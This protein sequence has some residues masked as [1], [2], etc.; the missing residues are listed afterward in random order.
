MA[1]LMK[2][3]TIGA[4]SVYNVEQA[5]GRNGPNANGDVKLVQYM[6]KHVYGARAV[7]LA[8]D[9]Y[10]GPITVGWIDTFQKEMKAS[11]VNVLTD[12]RVDRAFAEKST[13]SKTFY[14]I[15]ALNSE[16]RN[17]NP[18]AYAGLPGQVP[19]NPKPRANP[20]NPQHKEIERFS[21]TRLSG[22]VYEITITY[23]DGTML[24]GPVTGEFYI[25]HQR[26]NTE[27]QDFIAASTYTENGKRYILYLYKNGTQ[28]TVELPAAS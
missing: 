27:E 21:V 26:F 23:T 2:G 10:I 13:V 1:F 28:R 8:V 12:S 9:G 20:Y 6:L 11:V 7:G 22:D 17:R 16:L 3:P 18:A 24:I 19:L 15:L 4:G 5:V 14:T 25:E